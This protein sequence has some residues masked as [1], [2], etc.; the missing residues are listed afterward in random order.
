MQYL[1]FFWRQSNNSIFHQEN[2]LMT[3]D[4]KVKAMKEKNNS[5]FGE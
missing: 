5:P 1:L 2:T 3:N 4:A